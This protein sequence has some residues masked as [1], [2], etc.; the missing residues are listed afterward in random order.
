MPIR[1]LMTRAGSTIQKI[2]PIFMMSP[3]SVA[4]YLPPGSINFDLI[5]I[6]EASQVRPEDALGVIA[7]GGQ[8]VVVGDRKQLPPTTFF[9]RLLDSD[10]GEE[11]D[12]IE[13]PLSGAAPVT[14]LESILTLAEARGVASRM[15]R[16]HYR[17]R[18][19]SLIEV[20]NAEFYESNLF[21]PPSPSTDRSAEGLVLR[22]VIGA[23]DRGGKRTNAIEA[24]A[25]VD[26][27]A[28]HAAEEPAR[29]L[30]VVSF[31]TAQ[32]DLITDLL[33]ERRRRDPALESFLSEDRVEECFIKN[34]ENVQGD[35]RDVIV[36][37]VGYGP[38]IGGAKLESMNFGPVSSEG[39]ERRL[40][41]LFTRARVRTEVF[42][43][44]NSGDIDLGRAR[45]EG[46]RVLKRF[47]T[48]AESGVLDQPVSTGEDHDSH[49]EQD[50]AAIVRGLGYVVDAQVGSAGFK[51]DL[52]VRD[53]NA[54][55]RYLA[56]IE[57]DGATYHHALW[58]R[59][60]DRL[61]QDV[62]EKLGWRF[63]RI[64][65]TDWFY[66]RKDEIERLS[67]YLQSVQSAAAG[68]AQTKPDESV[69]EAE[70]PILD[71]PP[72]S[73]PYRIAKFTINQHQEPHEVSA[74]VMSEIVGKVIESEGPI[75]V[76]ELTRR[77]ASLWGKDRTGARIAQAVHNGLNHLRRSTAA[78]RKNGEFLC[79]SNQEED[80][81]IRD[82][83]NA[84]NSLQRAD[85]L[86]PLE[87]RA[88]ALRVLEDNGGIGRDEIAVAVTRKLGFQRTGP[89]LRAKIDRE[90]GAMLRTGILS[91]DQGR[92]IRPSRSPLQ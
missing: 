67:K 25:I 31:S 65:S 8:L 24:Q 70:E 81:P 12:E 77:V 60:R 54:P 64:W 68:P 43:S 13:V 35:E 16:W 86:P 79:T 87:I 66:R 50:V 53:P 46:P 1:K 21:L 18:H 41:V 37:S 92:L 82:R 91:E 51:I 19:P 14:E 26:A 6:D 58:A 39:G 62:L 85:M 40:N 29:S 44:F 5:V 69:P 33:D 10:E 4:Q 63:H 30:G 3:I 57:C 27:M 88:C 23:Y 61:R 74:R 49:F 84:I 34:L 20:S 90:I 73:Q 89:E 36:I 28:R 42:V 71:R 59:E 55:G 75:H 48:Y 15:L 78:I 32:R 56:A 17:S 11:N 38:R 83:A 47:L 22:R 52:A 9:S 45:G 2:K 72:D 76:E 7:R 80:C